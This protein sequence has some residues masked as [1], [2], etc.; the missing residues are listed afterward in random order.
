MRYNEGFFLPKKMIEN[1]LQEIHT[2]LKKRQQQ[3]S[4]YKA[5]NERLNKSLS[6]YYSDIEHSVSYLQGRKTDSIVKKINRR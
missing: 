5:V 1:I 6:S 4:I 3:K 2:E